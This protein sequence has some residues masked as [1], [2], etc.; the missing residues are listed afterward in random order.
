MT[1]KPNK[2]ADRLRYGVRLKEKFDK[3]NISDKELKELL[4][5]T[6][7][8]H[9]Y[10]SARKE[11]IISFTL[12]LEYNTM[13]SVL[14]TRLANKKEKSRLSPKRKKMGLQHFSDMGINYK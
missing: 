9:S 13:E 8:L 11:N 5:I 2:L 3:S 4:I 1:N 6:E 10:F 14:N 12:A 7:A